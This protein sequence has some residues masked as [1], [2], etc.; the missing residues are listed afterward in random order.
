VAECT[1]WRA[2]EL[3]HEPGQVDGP[4]DGSNYSLIAGTSQ[5]A[6]SAGDT[7]DLQ[8]RWSG[9]VRCQT[10]CHT[11]PAMATTLSVRLDDADERD[12]RSI[13]ARLNASASDA[14]RRLIRAAAQPE[15]L[16]VIKRLSWPAGPPDPQVK[17]FRVARSWRGFL[18]QMGNTPAGEAAFRA[19]TVL[20]RSDTMPDLISTLHAR[21]ALLEPLPD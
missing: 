4:C 13:A 12:L 1:A 5:L 2:A 18:P 20:Q 15:G 17:R 9:D 16:E 7:A 14:V 8:G 19:G 10:G 3:I 6:V 21:G 11:T